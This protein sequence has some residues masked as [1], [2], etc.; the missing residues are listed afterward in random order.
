MKA[1]TPAKHEH[2]F[3]LVLKPVP[4]T[5]E[6]ISQYW[7]QGGCGHTLPVP[8]Q[9][10]DTALCGDKGQLFRIP[11]LKTSPV[12]VVIAPG[13]RCKQQ[14][15]LSSALAVSPTILP[16]TNRWASRTSHVSVAFS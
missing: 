10:Q 11:G 5:P 6:L 8:S 7:D 3:Q 12:F 2:D 13:L 4:T 15:G 16:L 9:S 14:G 1:L